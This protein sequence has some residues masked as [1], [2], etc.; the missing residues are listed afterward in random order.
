MS[1]DFGQRIPYLVRRVNSALSQRLDATLREY[2][3]T[4]AQL[5]ALAILAVDRPSSRS[6]A[7]LSQ[8]S[9]VTAQSMSAAVAGLLDRGAVSRE[10]HPS[11][12]RIQLVSITE[13]GLELVHQVQ[14]ASDVVEERDMDGLDP[15]EQQQLRHLLQRMMRHLNLYLPGETD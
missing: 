7:E 11:H 12:G 5:S 3:L 4:Q 6:N 10:A 9:G 14:A 13:A 2:A 1:E 15:A 8:R